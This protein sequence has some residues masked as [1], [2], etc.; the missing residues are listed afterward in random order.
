MS[1]AL[2][3]SQSAFAAVCRERDKAI[4]ELQEAR[5]TLV[6]VRKE[7]G[8]RVLELK[9][10]RDEARAALSGRTVSCS[11][12]NESAKQIEAMR[13]AIRF[14]LANHNIDPESCIDKLK[15][16]LP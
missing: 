16:F 4:R 8:A 6:N 11:Q 10:E 3:L 5:N 1:D 15:P 14:T 2:N 9:K 12:C 7:R 13:E